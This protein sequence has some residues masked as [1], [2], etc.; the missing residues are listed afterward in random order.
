MTARSLPLFPL[1]TV[2]FPKGTL[3][4]QIFEE[5]YRLMLEHCL[6][7]DSKFGVVLIKRGLEVGG[8]ATTYN[9]GTVA[10]IV[11]VS[12]VR[13]GRI[14]VSVYGMERFEISRVT[15]MEPYMEAQIETLPDLED[16]PPL[17]PERI[18]NIREAASQHVRLSLGMRAGWTRDV[19][20]PVE[21]GD[22]SYY[23]G[24]RDSGAHP[25]ETEAA[26]RAICGPK[27]GAR[28]AMDGL[29]KGSSKSTGWAEVA[30]QEVWKAIE[31]VDRDTDSVASR[32]N[33]PSSFPSLACNVPSVR[34]LALS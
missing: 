13:E 34:Y 23:L 11:Q 6:N 15:Q 9:I 25:I 17:P 32:P 4:L 30:L 18:L 12:P 33:D 27:I 29:D 26:R 1:Q 16:D 8:P 24:C 14:F 2:L 19:T 7:A 20:L 21:L 28:G 22:L 3:P 31:P 10:R 5:R